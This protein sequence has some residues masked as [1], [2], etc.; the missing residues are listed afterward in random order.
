MPERESAMTA[1]AKGAF[2]CYIWHYARHPNQLKLEPLIL[3]PYHNK[4][5]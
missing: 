1:S 3:S 2:D 5:A 4:V